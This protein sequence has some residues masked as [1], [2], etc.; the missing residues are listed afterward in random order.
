MLII[1]EI[2]RLFPEAVQDSITEAIIN[3]QEAEQVISMVYIITFPIPLMLII[4]EIIRLF[5]EAVQEYIAEVII[6]YPEMEPVYNM[7]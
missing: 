4:M 3:Y 1:M 5:P 6:H 2:I 7:V